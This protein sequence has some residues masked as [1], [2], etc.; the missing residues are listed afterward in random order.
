MNLTY[1]KIG[2]PLALIGGILGLIPFFWMLL[3]PPSFFTSLFAG[4][5]TNM[6]FV[7]LGYLSFA[8]SVIIV[9]LILALVA[10]KLLKHINTILTLAII[11]GVLE[12]LNIFGFLY[13]GILGGAL[14]VIGG[15]M[16][17]IGLSP[18]AGAKPQK[19]T[20]EAKAKKSK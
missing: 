5:S 12:A 14:A 20:K 4:L 16:A 9:V 17:K 18:G 15:I 2:I 3:I 13:L 19:P 11:L 8:A 1:V 7:L 6:L 10:K